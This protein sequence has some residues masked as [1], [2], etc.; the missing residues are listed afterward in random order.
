MLRYMV[1]IE[2]DGCQNCKFFIHYLSRC[3]RH[4][5]KSVDKR[6]GEYIEDQ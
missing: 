5:D 6:N 4:L 1:G 2:K 3:W